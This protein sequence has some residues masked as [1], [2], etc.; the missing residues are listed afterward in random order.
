M[1]VPVSVR[2]YI[3]SWDIEVEEYVSIRPD[4]S[5]IPIPRIGKDHKGRPIYM[6]TITYADLEE[7]CRA[8]GDLRGVF[9][10]I[11]KF[12]YDMVERMVNNAWI[13]AEEEEENDA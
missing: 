10:T 2:S 13:T 8:T 4:G 6:A 9:Y 1:S 5:Y 3:L 7:G 11:S 12:D